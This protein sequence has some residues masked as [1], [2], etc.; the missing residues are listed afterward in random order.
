MFKI[1]DKVK[2]VD[3]DHSPAGENICNQV[4]SIGT[5]IHLDKITD[6]VLVEFDNLDSRLKLWFSPKDLVLESSIIT[7]DV[8]K[9]RVEKLKTMIRDSVL[10]VLYNND[11]SYIITI[12]KDP[13]KYMSAISM[14]LYGAETR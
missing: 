11:Y 10:T 7:I 3:T 6:S 5:I 13:E 8:F 14:N 12:L 9:E 1:G 2:V 4:G